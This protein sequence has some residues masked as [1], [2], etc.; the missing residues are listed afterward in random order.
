[1]YSGVEGRVGR[2]FDIRGALGNELEN[3]P[4]VSV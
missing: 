2:G 3:G 1:M 4:E